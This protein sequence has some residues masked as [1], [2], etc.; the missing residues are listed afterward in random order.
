ME[1]RSLFASAVGV[2][3]GV[4]VG[5]GLVSARLTAAPISGG[6]GEGRAAGAELEAELR[7]LVIDGRE[8]GVTFD[9]FPYYL[10][11]VGL[12]FCAASKLKN[13]LKTRSFPFA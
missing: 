13:P 1:H 3:V 2:G 10:R 9:K 12:S 7:G 8:S 11:C 4:G 5:I 6:G